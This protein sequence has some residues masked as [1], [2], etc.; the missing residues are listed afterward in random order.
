V[1]LGQ[2]LTTYLTNN[3]YD[4]NNDCLINTLTSEWYVDVR[5]NGDQ[6]I[7]Y[8]FFD[9]Y[10]YSVSGTSFPTQTNWLN[11]LYDSLPQMNSNGLT[12]NIDETTNIVTIY[13]NN[14]VTLSSSDILE[15]N[16]GINFDIICN[17]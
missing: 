15:L 3:G 4:L 14:C 16:V 12:F 8:K 9:G 17:Q 6:I 7:D 13:N 5:L 10:G 11:A 2:V 1:V